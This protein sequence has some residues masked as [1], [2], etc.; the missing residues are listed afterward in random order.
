MT[1]FSGSASCASI[2]LLYP[3]EIFSLLDS[4]IGIRMMRHTAVAGHSGA[5]PNGLPAKN[6]PAATMPPPIIDQ[7]AARLL[8]LGHARAARRTTPTTERIWNAPSIWLRI[9]W[10][11]YVKYKRIIF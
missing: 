9:V 6:Q 1:L 11:S 8:T 7:N 3:S 2:Y 5:M 10:P 4:V